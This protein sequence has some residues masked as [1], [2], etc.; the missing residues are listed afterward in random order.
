MGL[1]LRKVDLGS[2]LVAYKEPVPILNG[3]ARDYR[4]GNIAPNSREVGSRTV[5]DA[6]RSIVQAIA[7]L[8]PKDPQMTSTGKI[9]FRLQLQFRCYSR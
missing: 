6:V 5:E 2:L 8:G 1:L 9:N 3:F 4:T 7:V